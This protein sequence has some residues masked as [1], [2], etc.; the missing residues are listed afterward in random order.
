M[1]LKAGRMYTVYVTV[2]DAL[3]IWVASFMF[4]GGSIF[5][6]IFPLG[7]VKCTL[8]LSN[9]TKSGVHSSLL[10]PLRLPGVPRRSRRRPEH[11]SE[12]LSEQRSRPL[13]PRLPRLPGGRSLSGGAGGPAAGQIQKVGKPQIWRVWWWPQD[14]EGP[15]HWWNRFNI[16]KLTFGT[17]HMSLFFRLRGGNVSSYETVWDAFVVFWCFLTGRSSFRRGSCSWAPVS[18]ENVT[19]LEVLT[20]GT[21]STALT[22]A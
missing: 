18:G 19:G 7:N 17:L 11:E 3:F 6:L 12:T 21:S 14:T 1:S 13:P 15:F 4:W 22:P 5:V 20:E 9:P 8:K 16:F 10:S 2:K